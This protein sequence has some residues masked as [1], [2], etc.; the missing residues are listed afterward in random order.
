[1]IESNSLGL[2]YAY[3]NNYSGLAYKSDALPSSGGGSVDYHTR[4]ELNHTGPIVDTV[5]ISAESIERLNH[6]REFTN[7]LNQLKLSNQI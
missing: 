4:H 6:E 1:M 5:E 3:Y 2:G 7:E